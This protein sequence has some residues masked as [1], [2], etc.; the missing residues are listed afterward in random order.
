MFIKIAYKPTACAIFND[1]EN[2]YFE[3]NSSAK[4]TVTFMDTLDGLTDAHEDF[5][6]NIFT[7]PEY[8]LDGIGASA[9]GNSDKEYALNT[10]IFHTKGN[11]ECKYILF[12]G[13]AYLCD[14][15]GKTVDVLR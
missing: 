1:V 7:C 11:P 4:D 14:D 8:L 15:T 2:I 6:T 13:S 12:T 10:I 9:V 3:S 5:I